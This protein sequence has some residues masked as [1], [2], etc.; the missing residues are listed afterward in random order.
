MHAGLP[1]SPN[2]DV[3]PLFSFT[4]AGKNTNKHKLVATKHEKNQ[5]KERKCVVVYGQ[6]V[7]ESSY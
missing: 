5:V 7:V 6:A 4:A 1:A 2:A 3:G